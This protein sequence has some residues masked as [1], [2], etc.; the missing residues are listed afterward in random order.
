MKCDAFGPDLEQVIHFYMFMFFFK[1]KLHQVCDLKWGHFSPGFFSLVSDGKSLFSQCKKKGG[2]NVMLRLIS[3]CCLKQLDR[4]TPK[5]AIRKADH[6][7]NYS[8]FLFHTCMHGAQVD[9][10]RAELQWQHEFSRLEVFP[11]C[12]IKTQN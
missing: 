3:R 2:K 8:H 12:P 11:K 5:S 9:N 6:D 1:N 4:R 7:V 10:S